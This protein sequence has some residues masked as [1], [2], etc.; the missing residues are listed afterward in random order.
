MYQTEHVVDCVVVSAPAVFQTACLLCY[1]VSLDHFVSLFHVRVF[2]V[3]VPSS[4]QRN[5][6]GDSGAIALAEGIK[7]NASLKE[8]K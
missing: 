1:L 3:A 5:Q 8:L 2:F 6:I 7:L 4:L